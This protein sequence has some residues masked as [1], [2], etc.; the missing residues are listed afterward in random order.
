MKNIKL[1]SV[2]T[3]LLCLIAGTA[4]AAPTLPKHYPTNFEITG[5]IT[6]IYKKRRIIELDNADYR[7]HPVHDIFTLRQNSKTT[8]YSLKPGM[9]I[10]GEFG[11]YQGKRV[12]IKIWILPKS[13]PTLPHA[14]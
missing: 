3:L 2:I 10:G 13:Y 6:K 5:T 11:I 8:L 7:V 4:F 9:K 1:T 14:V 12:L